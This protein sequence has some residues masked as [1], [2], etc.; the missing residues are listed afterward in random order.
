MLLFA[1]SM[2]GQGAIAIQ[3]GKDYTKLTGNN[4]LHL[5][6]LVRFGRFD[7]VLELTERPDGDGDEIGSGVWDFA[8]G[9]AQLRQGETDFARAHLNRLVE[10]SYASAQFRRHNA[11]DLLG[12]LAWILRGEIR[13]AEGDLEGAIRALRM[14]N[15]TYRGL[16]YDEPE[17]LPFAAGHWLAAALIEAERYTEAEEVYREE[18][19]DHPHNGWS[20]FGLQQALE[21]QGKTDTE[22][23]SDFEA[24]WSRSDTWI[25]GSRF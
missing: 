9:Y 19:R 8:H 5:L 23:D 12:S 11:C 7:E 16:E 4:M 24:S 2:D 20:L 10:L 17:P 15:V 21:G 13:R 14:A 22:V 6:T 1:A 18:L 25:R 3:A